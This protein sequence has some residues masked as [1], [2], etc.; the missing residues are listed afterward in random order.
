MERIHSY[1]FS[2]IEGNTVF[3]AAVDLSKLVAIK[4]GETEGGGA[5]LLQTTAAKG[6]VLSYNPTAVDALIAAWVG[7]AEASNGALFVYQFNDPDADDVLRKFAVLNLSQIITL[8]RENVE[9]PTGGT[10]LVQTTAER[11]LILPYHEAT[12]NALVAAWKAHAE[13]VLN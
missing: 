7:H 10:V 12:L 8:K 6:M 13:R 4:L 5:I 3:G 2:T 9:S 11:G 1:N